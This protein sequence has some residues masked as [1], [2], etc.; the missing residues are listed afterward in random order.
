MIWLIDGEPMVFNALKDI[1]HMHLHMWNKSLRD[2]E[3]FAAKL[4]CMAE[5]LLEH[6]V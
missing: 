3:G 5:N 6:L 4:F 1:L 2:R